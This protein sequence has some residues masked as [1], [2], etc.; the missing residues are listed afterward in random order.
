MAMPQRRACNG[1]SGTK[2]ALPARAFRRQA[3]GAAENFHQRAF[4]GAV[5]S[6]QRMDF[7]RA[8][9]ERDTAQAWVAPKFFRTPDMRRRSGIGN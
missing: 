2:V 3:A 8:D 6:D 7:T 4:A 1:F 9:L 5:L